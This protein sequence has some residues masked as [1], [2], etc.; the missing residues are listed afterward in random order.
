MIPERFRTACEFCG[1]P[2][3]VRRAG[4]HQMMSG[5]VENRKGGGA[6]AIRL[7]KRE[8]RWACKTCVDKESSGLARYQPS[9]FG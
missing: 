9:L 7:P 1:D 8:L 6:H 5:W 4:V 3:D 2:L